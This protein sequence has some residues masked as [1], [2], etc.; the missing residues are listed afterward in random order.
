MKGK[1]D[2]QVY[3]QKKEQLRQ[4]YLLD[5]QGDIDLLFTDESAFNLIPC[6][7]YGWQPIGQQ[8]TIRSAR[9][10][11]TN[12]FGLMS[13]SGKLSVYSTPQN[14]NSEF[15]ISCI[16]EVAQKINRLTV[17]V[18]DNAPWHKSKLVLEKQE[19]WNEK[20]LYLFFLPTYSP[21]LNPIEILWKK[22]KYEWL[23][24]ADYESAK[25]LKEAIFYIIENYDD[26]FCINFSKNFLL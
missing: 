14:I 2:P 16:D 24:A 13:L 22:I 11:A 7:P 26:E 6:I 25:K 9:D 19:E 12:L 23:K 3:E 15:I 8:L 10:K 4:L 5:K 17:L 18:L 20:G 21:H 1:P